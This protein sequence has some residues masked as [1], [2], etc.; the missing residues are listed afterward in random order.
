MRE[1]RE[2]KIGL[3]KE[4]KKGKIRVPLKIHLIKMA[5]TD[6][7]KCVCQIYLE[8]NW[9]IY[10]ESNF[11][12]NQLLEFTL[13]NL[14]MIDCFLSKKLAVGEAFDEMDLNFRVISTKIWSEIT[15]NWHDIINF[16][17]FWWFYSE[18]LRNF[19][20]EF[21]V[22]LV[23]LRQFSCGRSVRW[24]YSKFLMKLLRILGPFNWNAS[25]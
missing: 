24:Y 4:E 23:K 6:R 9:C 5:K 25:N 11:I 1:S 2:K 7:W 17:D 19:Y 20:S 15:K 8:K 14:A 13:K 3:K 16:K 10:S 12:E 18:F 21:Y 22:Y